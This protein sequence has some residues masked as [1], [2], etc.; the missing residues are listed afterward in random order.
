[1]QFARGAIDLGLDLLK[2]SVEMLRPTGDQWRLA[3]AL[4]NLGE[5]LAISGDLLTAKPLLDEALQLARACDDPHAI[6]SIMD[7]LAGVEMSLGRFNDARALWHECFAI[8]RRLEDKRLTVYILERRAQIAL[9]EG[10]PELCIRLV[11]ASEAVRASI[12]EVAPQDWREIVS[13]TVQEARHQLS[14]LAAETA[15]REGQTMTYD[16]V[17]ASVISP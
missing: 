14:D 9:L 3:S 12:G 15:R 13:K 11:S 4:N 8:A 17:M 2:R 16:E 1:V 5:N 7:S 10:N 6:A